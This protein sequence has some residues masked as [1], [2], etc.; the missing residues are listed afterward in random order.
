[1]RDLADR[2]DRKVSTDSA[3][4]G[5]GGPGNQKGEE[6]L[7]VEPPVAQRRVW[8]TALSQILALYLVPKKAPSVLKS[9][10]RKEKIRKL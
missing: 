9:F 10:L 7:S 5:E 1:M 4:S 2:W 3:L 6:G 8:K